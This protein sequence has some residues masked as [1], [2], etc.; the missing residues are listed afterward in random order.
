MA[1]ESS[2]K[3]P[4]HHHVPL[5]AFSLDPDALLVAEKP[6]PKSVTIALSIRLQTGSDIQGQTYFGRT[7]AQTA[8]ACQFS[9]SR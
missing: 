9:L 4:I 8:R 2:V 6:L 5:N 1:S 3:R 7:Q